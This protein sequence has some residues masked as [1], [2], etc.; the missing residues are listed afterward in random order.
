MAKEIAVIWRRR[1]GLE[2]TSHCSPIVVH[3]MEEEEGKG[4]ETPPR[5]TTITTLTPSNWTD[6]LGV[7]SS[8]ISGGG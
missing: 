3:Q 8:R 5:I 2:R 7:V 1:Q 6:R 4:R